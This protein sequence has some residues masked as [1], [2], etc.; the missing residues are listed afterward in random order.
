MLRNALAQPELCTQSD[1]VSG[2][3]ID[4]N[5]RRPLVPER[6]WFRCCIQRCARRVGT[7]SFGQPSFPCDP[8]LGLDNFAC[9]C[10]LSENW[11]R[12]NIANWRWTSLT[13]VSRMWWL[14]VRYINRC[15]P[16]SWDSPRQCEELPCQTIGR[17]D[18]IGLAWECV[19][20]SEFVLR[21]ASGTQ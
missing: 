15:A 20:S 3:R 10:L 12:E 13:R 11:E 1:R 9:N 14:R 19:G 21:S 2:L 5:S 18:R 4:P 16:R 17:K 8:L 6:G 7:S